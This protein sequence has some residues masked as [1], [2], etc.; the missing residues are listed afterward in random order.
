MAQEQLQHNPPARRVRRRSARGPHVNLV[1]HL[2]VGRM[3]GLAVN[4]I[5]HNIAG[6]LMGVMAERLRLHRNCC[7]RLVICCVTKTS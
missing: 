7:D 3:S 1:H 6:C 4:F 2:L 5:P